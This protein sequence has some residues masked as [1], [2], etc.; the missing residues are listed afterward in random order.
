MRRSLEKVE[1]SLERLE[2]M[3]TAVFPE[4]GGSDVQDALRRALR[5]AFYSPP[6]YRAMLELYR[7]SCTA[8]GTAALVEV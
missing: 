1:T 4:L 3:F 8:T 6:I 2:S 5:A 7:Y